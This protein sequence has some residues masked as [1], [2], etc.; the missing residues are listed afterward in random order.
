MA[1][2]SHRSHRSHRLVS[3]CAW[4]FV[5]VAIVAPRRARAEEERAKL[6]AIDGGEKRELPLVQAAMD[7][8]VRGPIAQVRLT[9]RFANPSQRP[10][11]AIYVFPMHQDGAIGA[12]TMRI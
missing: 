11:E 6:I 4:L 1:H 7:V 8:A 10:I 2:R 9:Q 5:V 3:W 12:M